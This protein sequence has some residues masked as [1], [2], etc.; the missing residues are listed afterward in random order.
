MFLLFLVNP[1]HIQYPKLGRHH[2]TPKCLK[3]NPKQ[4]PQTTPNAISWNYFG[5]LLWLKQ[6]FLL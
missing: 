1:V 5:L 4:V 6:H 2:L 3:K